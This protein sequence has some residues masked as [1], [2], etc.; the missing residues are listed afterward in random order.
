MRFS[1]SALAVQSASS[2]LTLDDRQ[3]VA[4]EIVA[5]QQ[6]A[7]FQ[8]D[9]FEQFG[10]VHHV[11]LVQSDHDVRHTHLAGEQ[12]VLAGLR[13]RAVGGGHHQ[14]RA[15]HL[16]RAG[17]HV[18]D[19]VGVARAVDVRI[20]ALA[21]SYSTCAV[22]IVIPRAF[23]SGALSIWSKCGTSPSGYASPDTLVMAAVSV[24]LPWS[25]CPIVPMLTCGLVR[26]NFSF[27]IVETSLLITHLPNLTLRFR[28]GRLDQSS[29]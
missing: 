8:L 22:L 13:H 4:R 23:S 25:T 6:F 3:I 16:R 24:V 9:E 12:N 21:V 26:S 28:N 5:G 19:V 29:Q 14:D 20:V 15:V 10:I 11:D 1:H 2:A 27:A 7:N 18:L 17:N